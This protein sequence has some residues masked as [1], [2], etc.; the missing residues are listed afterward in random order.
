M[1]TSFQSSPSVDAS[2][3]SGRLILRLRGELDL[4]TRDAMESAIFAAI[5]TAYEVTLDLRDLTFCDSTGL[6]MFLA[7]NEKAVANGTA[8]K[9]V[10][11]Q[12]IVA[13]VFEISGVDQLL[14][15]NA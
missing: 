11:L 14:D 15:I 9:L 7:A 1:S 6:A 2:Q 10:N 8:L 5:P 3:E 12:P 13:R 4:A